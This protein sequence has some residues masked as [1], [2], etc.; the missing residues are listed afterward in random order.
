MATP[1]LVTLNPQPLH[2]WRAIPAHRMH[3]LTLSLVAL[4]RLCRDLSDGHPLHAITDNI[5]LVTRDAWFADEVIRQVADAQQIAALI[6]LE[7]AQ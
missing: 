2:D 5:R 3:H 4:N 1:S 6:F 7:D